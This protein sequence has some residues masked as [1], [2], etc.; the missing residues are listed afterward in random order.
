[1]SP[2]VTPIGESLTLSN[3]VHVAE[4]R[5][6]QALEEYRE[7]QKTKDPAQVKQAWEKWASLDDLAIEARKLAEKSSDL[8]G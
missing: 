5:S 4:Q 8:L 7:A 6:Q 2:V 3:L 1:M